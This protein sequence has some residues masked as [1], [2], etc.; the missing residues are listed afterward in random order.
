MGQTDNGKVCTVQSVSMT[1]TAPQ[2]AALKQRFATNFQYLNPFFGEKSKC[3]I[4]IYP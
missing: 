2:K 1:K 3:W 4:S